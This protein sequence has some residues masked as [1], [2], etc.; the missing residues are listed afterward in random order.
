MT[1]TSNFNSSTSCDETDSFSRTVSIIV[2]VESLDV[3]LAADDGELDVG[4]AGCL[5]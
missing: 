4:E 5:G 3:V 2:N 1:S